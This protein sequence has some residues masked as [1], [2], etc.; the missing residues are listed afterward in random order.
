LRIYVLIALMLALYLFPWLVNPGAS[1]TP[2]AYDLAEWASLHP[3][4]REANLLTSFL[5]RLPLAC[6]ALT[7]AFTGQRSPLRALVMVALS[8]AVLRPEFF[9]ALGDPN[10]QQQAGLAA[11]ALI[12]G[13]VGLSGVLKRWHAWIAAGVGIVGAAACVVGVANGYGLMRGFS[14]PTQV[15]MGGLGLALMFGVV[16]AAY[17]ILQIRQRRDRIASRMLAAVNQTG[18]R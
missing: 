12:G 7:V 14:L 1:L 4:V 17:L 10:Y 3:A 5:L 13:I 9:T 15:G 11:F 18:Q 6:L 8:L 2:N 16:A